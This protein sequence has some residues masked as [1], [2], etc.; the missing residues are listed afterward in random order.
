VTR[1]ANGVYAIEA[2]HFPTTSDGKSLVVQE[3]FSDNFTV[4]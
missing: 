1:G 3:L 2:T 4:T